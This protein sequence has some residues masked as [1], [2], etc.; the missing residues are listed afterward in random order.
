MITEIEIKNFKRFE[1]IKLSDLREITLLTGKNNSGKSTI[2]QAISLLMNVGKTGTVRWDKNTLGYELNS[3]EDTVYLK[4]A[5]RTIEISLTFSINAKEAEKLK[6]YTKEKLKTLTYTVK[7]DKKGLKGDSVVINKNRIEVLKQNERNAHIFFVD[8]NGKKQNIM[9]IRGDLNNTYLL[10]ID[11]SHRTD[12][13]SQLIATAQ[14]IVKEKIYN[15]RLLLQERNLQKWETGVGTDPSDVGVDGKNTVE[16]LHYIYSNHRKSKYPKIVET[17]KKF[18]EEIEDIS[19][20]IKRSETFI[21]VETK[22]APHLNAVSFGS[23]FTQIVPMIVELYYS[24]SESTILIEEPENHM[25]TGM[26]RD[27]I[28]VF[29]EVAKDENKQIIFTTHSNDILFYIY[30][31]KDTEKIDLDS[32]V[33]YKL[34]KNKDG[35]PAEILDFEVEV[36][37]RFKKQVQFLKDK[38]IN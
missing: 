20:P 27:L 10:G 22:F 30:R 25:H 32:L 12:E 34:I 6:E 24:P 17:L 31:F 23:G 18:D 21:D 38:L 37:D 11:L 4:D 7:I 16:L 9:G 33:G 19:S 1:H 35:V 14:Q 3:F 29:F 36:F 5:K 15:I 2:F 8:S 28:D 13:K 26:Q